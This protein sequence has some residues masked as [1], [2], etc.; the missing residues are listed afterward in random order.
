MLFDLFDHLERELIACGFLRHEDKRQQM[1]INIRNM[2]QRAE[3]T[4]QEIRTLH[5][6]IKELRYG[7]RPDRPR[8]QPGTMPEPAPKPLEERLKSRARAD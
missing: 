8:R 5:G 4:E 7:R 3:L 1:V 6:I 2:F